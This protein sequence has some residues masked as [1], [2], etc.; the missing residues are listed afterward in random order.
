MKTPIL[1]I[2]ALLL[3]S[4]SLHAQASDEG[5]GIPAC[6]EGGI[7]RLG[8]TVPPGQTRE[9][10]VQ[11]LQ[12]SGT[13]PE[14]TQIKILSAGERPA[15]VNPERFMSRWRMHMDRFF[16]AGLAVDGN[17]QTLLEVNADGVVTAVHPSTGNRDVDRGL[18][19]LW[20]FAQYEPLVVGGCRVP[21]WLHVGLQFES[22]YRQWERTQRTEVRP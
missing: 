7:A 8:I 22:E 1:A 3:G 6:A 19:D 13:L 10:L 14:G 21:A 16:R 4:V 9:E 5:T 17:A 2:T 20:R 12:Q 15:L 18:R 11:S